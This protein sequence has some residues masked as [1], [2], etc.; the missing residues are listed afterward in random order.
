MSEWKIQKENGQWVLA[1]VEALGHI[2]NSERADIEEAERQANSKGKTLV[3]VRLYTDGGM[4]YYYPV[5]FLP[6]LTEYT[7]LTVGPRCGFL[8]WTDPG[9]QQKQ[10]RR[11]LRD[12]SSVD[13]MD[14]TVL[15]QTVQ[16]IS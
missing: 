13:Y 1:H 4:S 5:Q 2:I 8:F 14:G 16:P 9:Y 11:K 10:N 3:F 15:F 6:K 12:D 7:T